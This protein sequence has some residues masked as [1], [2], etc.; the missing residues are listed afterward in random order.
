MKTVG[1]KNRT[2]IPNQVAFRKKIFRRKE[3]TGSNTYE[4]E[5]LFYS[6]VYPKNPVESY[7]IVVAQ[8]IG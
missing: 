5:C 8:F 1:V 3:I 6:L 7:H 2:A 4:I